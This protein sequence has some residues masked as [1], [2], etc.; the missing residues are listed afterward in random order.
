MSE[1]IPPS[2]KERNG[3]TFGG[4]ELA[5]VAVGKVNKGTGQPQAMT[6][7]LKVEALKKIQFPKCLDF[8]QYAPD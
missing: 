6:A 5:F 7:G 2:T 1:C 8:V 4:T 3:G